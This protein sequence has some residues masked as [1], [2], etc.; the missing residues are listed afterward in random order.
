[1]AWL[2]KFK[3]SRFWWV[4]HRVRGKLFQR[5][6]GHEKREDAER[7]L[8]KVEAQISAHKANALQEG[9]FEELTG[10]KAPAKTLKT[11]LADWINVT[12]GSASLATLRKYQGIERDL[13]AF[14]K[15]DD[16]GPLLREITA[17]QIH[18][19]LS[20]RRA[21]VSA[22]T[23]NQARRC[24]SVFFN[25]TDL[26][27]NPAK[28]VKLFKAGHAEKKSRRPFSRDEF[29][30]LLE[31]AP[32]DFWRYLVLGGYTTGLRM[33]DLVTMPI[34][35]PDLRKRIIT[36]KT[37][38]SGRLMHIPIHPAL[39]KVLSHAVGSRP[40]AAASD[41]F[42][43][44]QA[45]RFEESGPSWFSQRFYD[46][47]LV[48]AGLVVRRPHRKGRPTKV[49]TRQKNEVSF[50]CLR[51]AFVSRLAE[52]HNQQTVKELAGHLDDDVNDLYTKLPP[53]LLA[54]AV[55]SIEV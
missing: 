9:L 16:R 7:E 44:E 20:G 4:G 36:I 51:H 47:L 18:T 28:K 45:A 42:W 53:K 25:Q 49:R 11:A 55:K 6:T 29:L 39:H 8:A 1:M 48:K 15:A 31:V 19:F 5:S 17:E 26:K 43:P 38:K 10:R 33:G 32:D 52:N 41:P 23:T 24:L 22:S 13:L 12:R 40:D 14:F 2:F 30:K 3:N 27:E 50:H 21:V 46:L 54:D 37:R 35:A 34:G